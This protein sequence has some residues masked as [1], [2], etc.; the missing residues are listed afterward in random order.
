MLPT[1]YP[2]LYKSRSFEEDNGPLGSF[3]WIFDGWIWV[4][5]DPLFWFEIPYFL[6]DCPLWHSDSETHIYDFRE[7]T[8]SLTMAGLDMDYCMIVIE[9]IIN[10]LTPK[11]QLGNLVK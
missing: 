2:L 10:P 4:P 11:D 3:R 7:S 1:H 9:K 5:F 6:L 8:H